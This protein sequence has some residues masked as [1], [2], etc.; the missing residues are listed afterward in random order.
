MSQWFDES[1]ANEQAC[2]QIATIHVMHILIS[3]LEYI[4]AYGVMVSNL[5]AIRPDAYH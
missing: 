5:D 4:T 1:F 3:F 2:T